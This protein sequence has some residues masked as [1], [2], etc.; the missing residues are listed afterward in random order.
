M[1]YTIIGIENFKSKKGTD[2]SILHTTFNKTSTN[3]KCVEKFFILT[4]NVPPELSVG[5][6]VNVLYGPQG[7]NGFLSGVQII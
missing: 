3:C 4:A 6:E 7:A 2:I 1:I 5:D